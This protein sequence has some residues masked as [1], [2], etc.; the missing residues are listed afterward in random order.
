MLDATGHRWLAALSTSNFS[1]KYRPG[2]HNLDADSLSRHTHNLVTPEDEW[3]QIP[4]SGVR[5][6]CQTVSSSTRPNH[7]PPCVIEQ[8]GAHA[9]T[10]PKAFCH[11]TAVVADQLPIYSPSELQA[12]QKSDPCIGEVWLAISQKAPASHVQTN[13]PDITLTKREWEKL[14]IEQGLLY[15]TVKQPDLQSTTRV[16]A[17]QAVPPHCAEILA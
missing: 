8:M 12:A 11:P 17:P 13:H 6:L 9:S 16:N 2:R 10:I 3:Q 1:L 5:A 4:V 7:S 15:R 14:S